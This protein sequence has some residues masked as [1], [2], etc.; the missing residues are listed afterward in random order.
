MQWNFEKDVM[1]NQKNELQE[2]LRSVLKKQEELYKDI[3]KH[4]NAAKSQR[5][6]RRSEWGTR[7]GFLGYTSKYRNR[8][9]QNQSINSLSKDDNKSI[10]SKISN[11]EEKNTILDELELSDVTNRPNIPKPPLNI[12]HGSPKKFIGDKTGNL[13]IINEKN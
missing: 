1:N 7:T 10:I 6:T 12:H 2:Q 4:K 8:S 5:M 11:H 13:K 9:I 3:E